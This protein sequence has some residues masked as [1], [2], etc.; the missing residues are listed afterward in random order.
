MPDVVGPVFTLEG[1]VTDTFETPVMPRSSTNAILTFDY[2]LPGSQSRTLKVFAKCDATSS[3]LINIGQ[4]GAEFTLSVS[5]SDFDSQCLK[6]QYFIQEAGCSSNFF[7]VVFEGTAS[8][9]D[10]IHVR[11]IKFRPYDVVGSPACRKS[12][13][14]LFKRCALIWVFN[15]SGTGQSLTLLSSMCPRLTVEVLTISS[16]FSLL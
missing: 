1:T 7:K 15:Y 11:D 13:I 16:L 4:G 14:F 10:P 2:H 3:S 9:T 5:S 8:G 12:T 6:L